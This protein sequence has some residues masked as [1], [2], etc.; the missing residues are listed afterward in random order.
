[1]D[2]GMMRQADRTTLNPTIDVD[3]AARRRWD[4]VIAGAGPAGAVAARQLA[5]LDVSVLLVDKASFPR[6]KVCGCCLNGAALGTLEA[7]GLGD[8]VHRSG[9]HRLSRMHLAVGPAKATLRLPRAAALSREAFDAALIEE[10]IGAGAAFLPATEAVLLPETDAWRKVRLRSG[11]AES[12]VLCRLAIAADGLGGTFLRMTEGMAPRIT[13]SS[14]IGAGAVFDEAPEFFTPGTI[15]MACGRGAYVGAVRLEDGRLDVAA[16]LS[17][18]RLR[19][20]AG[21]GPLLRDTLEDCGFP[22]PSGCSDADWRGTPPLTRFRSRVAG[23]RLFVVGDSAGYVEPFT[24]EGMS[25]AIQAAVLV[26]SYVLEGLERWNPVLA[27]GWERRY[28]RFFRARKKVCL[29]VRELLRYRLPA[30]AA[31]ELLGRAPW[32]A[33]PGVRMISTRDAQVR[34]IAEGRS[35]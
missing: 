8:L 25:W 32:L 34:A 26:V 24:G 35:P 29:L 6:W 7:L 5:T 15:F 4:V 2:A 14:P 11:A 9:A 1:M 21:L 31:V 20:S 30:R 16:A 22:S 33:S 12:S 17:R 28:R 19:Q 27:A 13:P 23:H 18:K 3:E 10:A